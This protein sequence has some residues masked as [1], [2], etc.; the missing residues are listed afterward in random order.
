MITFEDFVATLDFP[1]T[2]EQARVIQ[3][4]ERAILVVAGAG[5]GKTATMAQRVAWKLIEGKVRPSQVLCLTFTRK[6]AG[7]LADRVRSQ[8][9]RAAL[10]D[11]YQQN[12]SASQAESSIQ[13]GDD[14]DASFN[15]LASAIHEEHEQPTISTYNSFAAEIASSYAM[16]IGEDPRSRLM[17]DA[18][19]WQIMH[20]IISNW[21]ENEPSLG[22]GTVSSLTRQ[23]LSLAAAIIDNRL[24]PQAVAD[25]FNS[26]AE[27]LTTIEGVS[28]TGKDAVKKDND[29]EYALFQIGNS[30]LKKELVEKLRARALLLPVVAE[31]FAVKKERS[32]IEFADQVVRATRIVQE[33]PEVG[34]RLRETY[35]LILLDEYQDTSVSQAALLSTAFNRAESVTAVGDP[36]QAIY[37]WRGASAN[38]L[39]D[40]AQ[41]FQVPARAMLTLSQAFRNSTRILDVANQLTVGKLSYQQLHV[42]ELRPADG[43]GA[44]QAIHIH[45]R[46]AKDS[47]LEMAHMFKEHFERAR[48]D[49]VVAQEAG[50]ICP[51]Q[52]FSFPTA[53]VLIRAGSYRQAVIEALEEV[54]LPYEDI[55]NESLIQRP[56]IV[57]VRALLTVI[58][59]PER[60]DRLA[61]LLN[62]YAVG[63]ADMAAL[64]TYAGDLAYR[65]STKLKQE[66]REENSTEVRVEPNLIEALEHLRK[67]DAAPSGMSP[68]GF[69]RLT[70]LAQIIWELRQRRHLALPDIVTSAIDALDLQV[71]AAARLVGRSIVRSS[72]GSFVRLS[73]QYAN[74]NPSASLDAFL[75]WLD[76]V[77]EHERGGESAEG[78]MDTQTFLPVADIE[79]EAGVVQILTVHAAK[80][81]EWDMV[82][83]PEMVQKRFDSVRYSYPQ[84]IGSASEF[85][86]PLRADYKHLPQ[87]DLRHYAPSGLSPTAHK[88]R[89]CIA[90]GQFY[91][92]LKAYLGNE[93]R[94]L[95]YVA[96]TRPRDLLVVLSYDVRDESHALRARKAH[97]TN[98]YVS[99]D[100]RVLPGVF[101]ADMAQS[102]ALT[103]SPQSDSLFVDDAEF[104]EW[105][106][107][108][109]FEETEKRARNLEPGTEVYWPSDVDRSLES[110]KRLP[111]LIPAEDPNQVD[112]QIA[113]WRELIDILRDEHKQRSEERGLARDYLTASDIVWLATNPQAF[114]ENQLRPLPVRPSV[115]A[116]RGTSVHSAIAHFYDRPA[117]LD[118]D[119]VLEA[120]QMPIDMNPALNTAE[121]EQLFRRFEVSRF[122]SAPQ[123]AI[124]QRLEIE[125]AGYPVRCV[126]DAVLD[127]S[128][129]PGARPVTIVDWKTGRRPT[130]DDL[131]AREL[132]LG[133]YRLAWSRAHNTPL[134]DIDACFYFLGEA[135]E[136]QRELVAGEL[137]EQR[138]VELIEEHLKRGE[139]LMA[140][141]N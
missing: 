87:F 19:R 101:I 98:K 28:N 109:D 76:A 15:E 14:T 135:E 39:V 66:M 125:L 67:A 141:N 132:Q 86:Y 78:A 85:P 96:V 108:Q 115:A 22:E 49:F 140:T 113:I 51:Q 3:S 105:V 41:D 56:E 25:F 136:S 120:D 80:G 33:V 23:A 16:L 74:D 47:Y 129:V 69:R 11:V 104:I 73:G 1:P 127:T 64:A 17:T 18:E 92:E 68:E 44:G 124:E 84:W 29:E 95:A 57:T 88:G 13:A 107:A 83:V 2:A 31:Y 50:A 38:A 45:H 94:R 54:G 103:V 65:H 100:G 32:L 10:H 42:K 82:A 133:I 62:F 119:S 114:Y 59:F 34:Q 137:S 30:T 26:Q 36:N 35:K 93:E 130:E 110:P 55:G 118:I 139:K 77:D 97:S 121:E 91:E 79:P 52:E 8:I 106:D 72:L 111:Q 70:N 37:G 90:Y 75:E 43:K 131:I 89:M 12:T 7:E 4:D 21:P 58:A 112:R 63:P 128:D 99:R 122:A 102:P 53:A 116:R 138:I 6:A 46:Q 123:L 20:D 24:D 117:T 61:H 134:E 48:R 40:F 60:T 81:L 5:S 126:I 27:V 71:Y 9:Q